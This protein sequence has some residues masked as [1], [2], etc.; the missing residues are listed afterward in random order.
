MCRKNHKITARGADGENSDVVIEDEPLDG[1]DVLGLDRGQIGYD[2][3]GPIGVRIRPPV[4]G[5]R[6]IEDKDHCAVGE[7]D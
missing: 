7:S 1:G 4:D 2:L 5:L 6:P 3:C